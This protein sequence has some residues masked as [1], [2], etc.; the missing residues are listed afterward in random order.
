M[1]CCNLDFSF[2]SRR[3]LP[4]PLIP[5]LYGTNI[6]TP[7]RFIDDTLGN[8][9]LARFMSIPAPIYACTGSRIIILAPVSEIAFSTRRYFIMKGT[10]DTNYCERIAEGETRTCQQLASAEKYKASIADNMA[11]PIYNKYYK[12]YAARVKV[13]QIK[14]E[15]FRKWKNQA[16]QKRDQCSDGLISVE[17]LTEWMEASFPN[18]KP[19]S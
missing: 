6:Q 17:E 7:L 1:Q 19:K 15:V 9:Q 13:R 18:R 12:R 5:V 3:Q 11:I 2:M 14:E 10:Y 8:T 16:I 4:V